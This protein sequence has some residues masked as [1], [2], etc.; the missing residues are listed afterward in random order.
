MGLIL[1]HFSFILSWQSNG[2]LWRLSYPLLSLSP[3][4]KVSKFTQSDTPK[5]HTQGQAEISCTHIGLWLNPTT[6]VSLVYHPVL[7][8]LSLLTHFKTEKRTR[9]KCRCLTVRSKCKTA[10][11]VA[12]FQSCCWSSLTNCFLTSLSKYRRGS[13]GSRVWKEVI[14]ER[15][16]SGNTGQQGLN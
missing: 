12:Y 11:F 16:W 14:R 5:P 13:A 6:A 9:W 2:C 8:S 7:S 15:E 4:P 3:R 1:P 10:P